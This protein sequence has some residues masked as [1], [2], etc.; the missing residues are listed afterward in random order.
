MYLKP[1]N[2]QLLIPRHFRERC[3]VVIIGIRLGIVDFNA[4]VNC[5]DGIMI[6]FMFTSKGIL[7]SGDEHE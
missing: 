4:V 1:I 6:I 3:A 5:N 7:S 2:K